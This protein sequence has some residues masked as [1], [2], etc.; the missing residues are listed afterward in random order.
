MLKTND[1]NAPSNPVDDMLVAD[2]GRLAFIR[3]ARPKSASITEQ[4]VELR[5]LGRLSI[6]RQAS[7]PLTWWFAGKPARK[8]ETFTWPD[9]TKLTV[10]VGTISLFDAKGFVETKVHYAGMKYADPM[11]MVYPTVTVDPKNGVVQVEVTSTKAIVEETF[12]DTE[13]NR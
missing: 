1:V 3:C 10:S 13:E 2:D 5:R 11:P 9:G 4:S 7:Q 8:D 12:S 6:H